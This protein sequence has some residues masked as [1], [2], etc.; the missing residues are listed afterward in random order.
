MNKMSKKEN[1]GTKLDGGKLES[2]IYRAMRAEGWLAPETIPEVLAAEK[3]LEDEQI[4]ISDASFE[5][6]RER[7]RRSGTG[8]L[9]QL[10]NPS[11]APSD[12]SDNL[13]RAARDGGD[14]SPEVELRMKKDRD[15]AEAENGDE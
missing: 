14:V 2:D 3:T 4:N 10:R 1:K 13:A 8:Q 11:L 12:I 6:L 9:I 15:A 7:L 5:R